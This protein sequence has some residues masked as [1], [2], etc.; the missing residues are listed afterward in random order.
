MSRRGGGLGLGILL[1][2]A[3]IAVA[4]YQYLRDTVVQ[5]GINEDQADLVVWGIIIGTPIL[6]VIF[7]SSAFQRRLADAKVQAEAVILEN[8]QNLSKMYRQKK[9]TGNYGELRLEA[10][11]KEIS[12]F[13]ET[14]L[15][16]RL[17]TTAAV[18]QD[19][20]FAIHC[21]QCIWNAIEA[22]EA[23]IDLDTIPDDP[24]EFEHWTADVL[25][26]FGWNAQATQGSGDQGSDVVAEFEGHTCIIQC[27]LY[28]NPVGNKAVQEVDAARTFFDGD[29]AAV[30]GKSG[31]TRSAKQLA[32]KNDVLLIDVS[33][34]SELAEKLDLR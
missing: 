16:P 7:W 31:F 29:S 21:E 24:F 34:L 6:F 18:L 27:K 9:Y 33:E 2:P 15:V 10:F 19:Q 26:N 5:F 32:E 14:I 20:R 3:A 8:G 11:D 22:N 17:A 23:P 4:I 25:N 13:Y 28:K 1:V 12:Y 30:V